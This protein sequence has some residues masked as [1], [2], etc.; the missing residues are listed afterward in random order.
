[1]SEQRPIPVGIYQ[2]LQDFSCPTASVRVFRLGA[3]GDAVG[4][5]IHHRSMQIY[6]ALEGSVVVEV[7]G[8]ERTLEPFDAMPVWAGMKHRASPVAGDALL[9]NISIPPLEA[10]D[11]VPI[12]EWGERPDMRL[13]AS[14]FDVDD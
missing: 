9:M 1:M 2:V 7:E 5:H 4:G 11:Q 10:D 8:V 14:D 13:P 12:A 6:V 3:E